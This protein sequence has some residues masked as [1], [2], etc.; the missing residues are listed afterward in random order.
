MFELKG[1]TMSHVQRE[2]SLVENK[3][4]RL[5]SSDAL[6]IPQWLTYLQLV[7]EFLCLATTVPVYPLRLSAVI[8]G[9][10][11][12]SVP[13]YLPIFYHLQIK[14]E[15]KD[16]DPWRMLFT[17]GDVYEKFG[18]ILDKW[19]IRAGIIG[20]TYSLYF[21]T[22]YN[23]RINLENR[24]LNLTQALESY[25]RAIFDGKYTSEEEYKI[26]AKGI[27]DN[28]P[29]TLDD[30]FRRS[31]VSRIKYGNELSLRRRIK[32]IYD[33]HKEVIQSI[34]EKRD[35]FIEDVINT[36]NYLTHHDTSVAHLALKDINLFR[37]SN[38]LQLIIEICL[39]SE[40]GISGESI[41]KI[42]S[43]DGLSRRSLYL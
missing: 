12:S 42:F 20:P 16:V 10:A 13:R 30:D 14:E 31:L 35:E 29:S 25:H 23:P 41:A 21:S 2:I 37:I 24:F 26:I 1:P 11:N 33:R 22:L 38:R 43:K 34:I 3:Y 6:S 9:E 28:L 17:F 7:S 4:W 36:R 8:P 15:L 19:I 40:I 18:E 27:I 32:E 39:L 5:K